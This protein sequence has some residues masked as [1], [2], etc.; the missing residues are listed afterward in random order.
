MQWLLTLLLL[1]SPLQASSNTPLDNITADDLCGAI[2]I[3]LADAVNNELIS[4]EQA[5]AILL[6]CE[7]YNTQSSL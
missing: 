2:A 6:R 7:L 1:A 5:L 3:E 4:K